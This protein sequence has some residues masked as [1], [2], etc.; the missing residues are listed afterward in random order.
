MFPG[1]LSRRLRGRHPALLILPWRAIPVELDPTG[2]RTQPVGIRVGTCE[3]EPA[4]QRSSWYPDPSV[5]PRQPE[6]QIWHP[7]AFQEGLLAREHSP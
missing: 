7:P 2:T 4:T 6:A 1:S 3:P 5:E